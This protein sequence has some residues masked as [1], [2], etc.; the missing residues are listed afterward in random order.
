MRGSIYIIATLSIALFYCAQ[1]RADE[2]AKPAAGK[3]VKVF[4]L[5]GQSNMEGRADGTKLLQKD[6]E[7]LDKVKHRI[8]LAYNYTPIRPLSVVK[9]HPSIAKSYK[10]DTLFGPEISFGIAMAEAWPSEQVL[11]IKVSAGSTSLYGCWNPDWSL[12]KAKLMEEEDEPHLYKALIDYTHDT[13]SAYAPDEYERCAMLWVQGETDSGT[14]VA[15]AEYGHN[16]TKLIH[17]VRRDFNQPELPFLL[18]QVGKGKVVQGMKKV[19]NEEYNITLLPRSREPDSPN[20][21]ATIPNGH[22]NHE[23]MSKLGYRFA[24]EYLK[25]YALNHQ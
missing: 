14:E 24:S 8:Q 1:G 21:Y 19:A 20:F 25:N 5:A 6:K 13:L 22:Y 9:A 7:R 17:G 2:L 10:I 4:I 15:A 16:L 12:E 11:L 3:K 23:G 18:F